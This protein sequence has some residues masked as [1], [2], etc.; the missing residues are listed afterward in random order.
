MRDITIEV[1]KVEGGYLAIINPTGTGEGQQGQVC[2]FPDLLTLVLGLGMK[3]QD[4]ESG[5]CEF[6]TENQEGGVE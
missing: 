4:L 6:A 2:G 1:K 3:L 5:R